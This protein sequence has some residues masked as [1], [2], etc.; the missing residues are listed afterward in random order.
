MILNK[1][2][3][4]KF[5]VEKILNDYYDEKIIIGTYNYLK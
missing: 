1:N 5:K 4:I 2:W 3:N